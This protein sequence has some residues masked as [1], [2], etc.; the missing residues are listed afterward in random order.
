MPILK[1]HFP[2][3][4]GKYFDGFDGTLFHVGSPKLHWIKDVRIGPQQLQ[5]LDASQRKYGHA[6]ET[7]P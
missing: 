1:R 2:P 3:C 6:I 7:G 4:D 5:V